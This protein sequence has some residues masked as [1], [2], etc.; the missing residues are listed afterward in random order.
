VVA[1]VLSNIIHEAAASDVQCR[2]VETTEGD[3][4]QT[5]RS[6]LLVLEGEN[7]EPLAGSWQGT[8]Q[9][10]GKSPYRPDHKRKNWFIGVDALLPP[11]IPRWTQGD[12]RIDVM[13][14]SGPGGQHVNK[15]CSAVRV[16][17]VPTGLSA[18]AQEER[19]QHQNRR[20]ALARLARLW[21]NRETDA[22]SEAKRGRWE[23][24]GMLERGNPVRTFRGKKF[25]LVG[26]RHK[27]HREKTN[28][29]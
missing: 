17:H 29:S 4:E 25:Q 26:D 20:L 2:V 28:G 14:S 12:L 24:H 8:V 11:V 22:G 16:T 1:Q 27:R 18:I 6:A 9:W 21:K 13:R 7:A 23:K 15:T 10:I 3:E 5:F 19:S